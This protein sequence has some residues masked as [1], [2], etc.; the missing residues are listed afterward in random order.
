[1]LRF[2]MSVIAELIHYQYSNEETERITYTHHS[3][4]LLNKAKECCS[5]DLLN[6]DDTGPGVFLLKLLVK[7]YGVTF[8]TN[9][10]SDATM[11][12]VVPRSLLQ[13]DDVSITSVVSYLIVL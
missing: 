4:L 8:L 1:M 9:L 11:E 2:S 10:T 12:W 13:S 7:Q 5:D 6:K 3:Q